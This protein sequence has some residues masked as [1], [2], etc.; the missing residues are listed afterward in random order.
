MII[1]LNRIHTT[2]NTTLGTLKINGDFICY[3]L[4]DTYRETKIP[5]RTRIPK[6]EYDVN[7]RFAGGMYERYSNGFE[8]DHPMLWIRNVPGFEYIYFHVLNYHT[9]TEGCVG[10]G[11]DYDTDENGD[12]YLIDSRDAYLEMYPIIRN[13]L[14]SGKK[15]KV[16]IKDRLR[17]DKAKARK[18]KPPELKINLAPE[19]VEIKRSV[20]KRNGFK[21]KAGAVIGILGGIFML[22]PYPPLQAIG[23]GIVALG[24]A[25]TAIGAGH[26]M[27]KNRQKDETT[28]IDTIAILRWV[29]DLLIKLFTKKGESK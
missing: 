9:E 20:F 2:K 12:Y 8:Y 19:N 18:E 10:V 23:T 14:G 17:Y 15:V 1:K 6:G 28:K 16:R 29:A 22:I 7:L 27:I 25:T 4:E 3:T 13:A 11:K 21:R 26:G 5:G 24:G